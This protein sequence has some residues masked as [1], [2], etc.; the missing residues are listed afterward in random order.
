[1]EGLAFWRGVI[2]RLLKRTVQMDH[3][4]AREPHNSAS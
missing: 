2:S 1:M 3:R 4:E